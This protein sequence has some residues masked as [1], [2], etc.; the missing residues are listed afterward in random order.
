MIIRL[1]LG[2][3]LLGIGYYLGREAGRS[4]VLRG[5]LHRARKRVNL[6]GEV[7]DATD[8]EVDKKPGSRRTTR[9]S[10]GNS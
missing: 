5:K 7:V 1:L 8:Y 2:A 9:T 4:D 3:G 6:S 10:R